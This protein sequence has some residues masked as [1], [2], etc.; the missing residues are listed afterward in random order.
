MPRSPRYASSGC[1][2]CT[3]RELKLL[4]L[5]RDGRRAA[6]LFATARVDVFLGGHHDLA[7]EDADDGAVL[8]IANGLDVDN[9]AVALAA[10]RGLVEN[11]G[12]AVDGVAVEGGGDV[13]QRFDL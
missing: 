2:C 6:R 10:G 11:G 8:L 1:R 9:P 7:A 5:A 12:L 13:A 4:L 3:P